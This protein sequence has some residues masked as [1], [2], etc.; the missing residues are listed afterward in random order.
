MRPSSRRPMFPTV[1]F[2]SSST[3]CPFPPSSKSPSRQLKPDCKV[4][5]ECSQSTR[6]HYRHRQRR[7]RPQSAHR[8]RHS[9]LHTPSTSPKGHQRRNT[10][11]M[12][13][14]S[15]MYI[16]VDVDDMSGSDVGMDT[17]FLVG[18]SPQTRVAA[19]RPKLQSRSP[20]PTHPTC[21]G[22]SRPLNRVGLELRMV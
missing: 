17:F 22:A 2:S 8:L 6:P 14:P 16:Q 21:P 18:S 3:S 11:C 7:S 13:T 9:L 1:I 20:A 10:P 15:C 4:H 5:M 12:R 19:P